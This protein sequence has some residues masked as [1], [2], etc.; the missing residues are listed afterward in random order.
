MN[1][2]QIKALQSAFEE[3]LKEAASKVQIE[4]IKKELSEKIASIKMEA[5][6][7]QIKSLQ[8]DF[9]AKLKAQWIEVEKQLKAKESAKQ[10]SG[11]DKMKAALIEQGFITVD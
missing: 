5:S 11:W 1:E 2:E 6:P 8:D 7:E 4:E 10:V 3:K 9:D